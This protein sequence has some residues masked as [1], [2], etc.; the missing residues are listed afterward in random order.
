MRPISIFSCKGQRTTPLLS[1]GLVG[2]RGNKLQPFLPLPTV[3]SINT[4]RHSVLMGSGGACWDF[5]PDSAVGMLDLACCSP[6]SD[7]S[8]DTCDLNVNLQH[9][10]PRS[11]RPRERAGYPY[12]RSLS[13]PP[14]SHT[15]ANVPHGLSVPLQ[16]TL[17]L[18]PM[19]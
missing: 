8:A 5:V 7:L 18:P 19:L 16:G 2:K 14:A 10:V 12:L 3:G 6:G 1:F 13:L 15:P 4:P 11:G 9:C 17:G